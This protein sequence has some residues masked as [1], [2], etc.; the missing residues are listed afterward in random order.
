[1]RTLTRIL[2]SL[3]YKE[4]VALVAFLLLFA[5][6]LLTRVI[7]AVA[8]NSTFV[9]IEGGSYTEGLV[10][11]PSAVNPIISANPVDQDI[12][13]LIYARLGDL[14]GAVTPEEDSRTYI[15]KLKEGLM[16]EDGV[17]LTSDD[18]V[19]TVKTIQDPVVRSP[20]AK[21]F[22]SVVVDRISELQVNF[23]LP[24]PY[25]FF[26]NNIDRLP[27][28][29]KH[30]FSTIPPANLR[31][32]SY[33][34][35][36]VSSG[37]Y[38][39]KKMNKRKDGF[40]TEYRLVANDG[41]A[42]KKPFIN[43]FQFKFYENE[44]ELLRAA[45][46]REIDGFGLAT[47]PSKEMSNLPNA[48]VEK[49]EMPRYYSI[50]F[51]PRATSKLNNVDFR[52]ALSLAID[53]NALV[54]NVLG[55]DFEAL[56]GP[57]GFNGSPSSPDKKTAEE[58]ISDLKDGDSLALKIMVPDVE[59]LK[60][61]AEFIER[62]WEAAGI[63]E[64]SVV[65]LGPSDFFDLII[66]ERNYEAVIFGNILEN[67]FDLFPFWHSSERFYPGLNLALYSN[68][69]VDI[70][71]ENIRQATSSAERESEFH[72]AVNL[73]KKDF[74]AVFLYSLPYIYIHSEKLGGFGLKDF[75]ITPSDRFKSVN[76]WYVKRA[77]VIK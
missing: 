40:I 70:A 77:R 62:D 12:S 14:A 13:A 22:E 57:Y 16:W 38:K 1:M 9:P 71:L 2:N 4:F 17:P 27:I 28:I 74:P 58:I 76:S 45:R 7:V 18:I 30:I 48:V 51:N 61:T 23:V 19:F 20:F 50:F 8:E 15:V 52:R 54:K 69:E 65:S 63:D 42:G 34:L 44:A 49:V 56:A 59:F 75:L 60:Q 46:S 21:N 5:F 67:A 37:P 6:S 47:P 55:E 64:V 24:A 72:K 29:P 53:K 3:T 11:Q 68:K 35:E 10:G 31:L 26:K 32:S 41:F 25:V 39:F 36:P 66:R 33:N 73:I 43:E